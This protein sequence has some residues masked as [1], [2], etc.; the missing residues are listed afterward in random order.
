[1][2]VSVTY[3][4]PQ[5][6]SNGL[7][8]FGNPFNSSSPQTFPISMQVVAP[9]W[10]DIDLRTKGSVRFGIITDTH[11]TL[12]CLPGLTS[13]FISSREGIPFQS[14]W[15]LV[16]RWIDTCPFSD[17]DCTEVRQS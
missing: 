11:A 9:Y 12:S 10:D 7:V 6:S 14:S 4:V 3:S 2:Y 16:A 15:V 8:S 1:M 5:V 13:E 17:N